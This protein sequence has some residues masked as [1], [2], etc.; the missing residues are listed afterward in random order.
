MA[1]PHLHRMLTNVKK[2]LIGTDFF[3]SVDKLVHSL[4]DF[5]FL[6]KSF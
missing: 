4:K 3:R 6:F 1:L 5:P 2:K